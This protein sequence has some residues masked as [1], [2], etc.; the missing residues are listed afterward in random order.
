MKAFSSRSAVK[1]YMSTHPLDF[2]TPDLILKQ[3]VVWL[4]EHVNEPNSKEK[5]LRIMLYLKGEDNSSNEGEKDLSRTSSSK[6]VGTTTEPKE[7]TSNKQIPISES[8]FCIECGSKLKLNS[9]FCT[10]CGTKQ[11]EV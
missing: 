7:N 9:K 2:S 3:F 1:E 8:K 5:I 4:C 10:K 11:V 6:P